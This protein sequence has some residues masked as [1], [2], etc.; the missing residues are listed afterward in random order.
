MTTDHV[1]RAI[2]EVLDD[3][4]VEA[5]FERLFAHPALAD[6]SAELE[7]LIRIELPLDGWDGQLAF[8]YWVDEVHWDRVAEVNVGAI[9]VHGRRSPFRRGEPV[10][11]LDESPI[12]T[13]LPEPALRTLEE[14][15]RLFAERY[16]GR[17]V[18]SHPRRTGLAALAAANA[19]LV[20]DEQALARLEAILADIDFDELRRKVIEFAQA[21]ATTIAAAAD[22]F[23]SLLSMGIDPVDGTLA[24]LEGI[25]VEEPGP[26]TTP[27]ELR[28]QADDRWLRRRRHPVASPHHRHR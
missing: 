22:A 12:I 19:R 1:L 20:E 16:R 18:E 17:F 21:A 11:T 15:R 5:A 9:V 3:V 8:P 13:T 4:G 26:R 24:E 14:Q 28:R 2:D 23:G 10:G 6:P 27:A 25:V 7:R